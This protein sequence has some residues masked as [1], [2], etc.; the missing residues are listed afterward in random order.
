MQTMRRIAVLLF[1]AYAASAFQA[2]RDKDHSAPPPSRLEE[3]ERLTRE[4]STHLPG[5]IGPTAKPVNFVDE[6]IFRSAR[7]AGI[8]LAAPATD[9]EFLRRASLDLTGHLPSPERIRKFLA[10]N[11]A[12]KRA[13]FID[14]L[15]DTSTKGVTKKPSTPFLDRWTYF[16]ADL[17]QINNL[18]LKGQTLFYQ[19]IRNA[20]LLDQPY[21][22]FVREIL[23]AS[24]RSNH[25]NAPV[26][27]FIRY[28]VDQP[29]QSQV[30][31]EDS[32]DEFAI[33]TTRMFLGIN[34]ECVSCHDGKGHLEQVNSW[35]TERKR[36]EL[37]RQAAFFG[38]MRLYRPYGQMVDEFIVSDDGKGYDVASKSVV[39]P[40]RHTA[41]VT[42]TF[43]LTGEKPKPGEEPRAA[44]ARMIPAHPQFARAAVNLIWAEMFGAGL[45]EPV[46]DWDLN[47]TPLHAELLD[48]LARDFVAH[49]YSLRHVIR[50]LANSATYQ[51]SHRYA[52]EWKPAYAGNFVRHLIRRLPAEQI[53]DAISDA[54]GS[55]ESLPIGT[56]GEKGKYVQQT[57]SAVDLPEK[58]FAALSSFGLN[59]RT[60]SARSLAFTPVQ[61]S[62][63]M[64][65]DL[66]KA[67]LKADGKGRLAL[68]W[69]SEPPKKNAEMVEELFLAALSRYPTKGETEWAIGILAEHHERG[70]E[71]IL[72]A[73]LN[74]G[75]FQLNY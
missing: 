65:S 31:H 6:Y 13:R 60:F 74:K 32:F 15:L 53:W 55:P 30:N 66:V 17:F 69:K 7:T 57:V 3:A 19:H 27:F 11:A 9:A 56:T 36:I 54:T 63:L 5:A 59:D 67:K 45:V 21:D 10:D 46:L 1:T 40:P 8:P 2:K 42:P 41:D 71:D 50:L 26:N 12:D 52:G 48:A 43:L 22:E 29:D 23:T 61:S 18:Q 70:A 62:I 64:N 4:Q 25:S 38:K 68:M 34:L 37:W 73:L 24:A 72:W 35:L 58:L 49:R 20:L 39:R 75:E 28:Y 14:D 33:R 44:Y 51:L 47:R 16:V